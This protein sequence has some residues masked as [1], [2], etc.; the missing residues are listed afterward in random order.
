MEASEG[1]TVRVINKILRIEKEFLM[2]LL[3][4]LMKYYQPMLNKKI[5]ELKDRRCLFTYKISQVL[6]LKLNAST[7]EERQIIV[8]KYMILFNDLKEVNDRLNQVGGIELPRPKFK[9]DSI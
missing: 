5:Q 4:W 8:T 7:Q 3:G 6:N 9:L 1:Y 2:I